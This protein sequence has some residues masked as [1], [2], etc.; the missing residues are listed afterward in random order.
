MKI[1]AV[2]FCSNGPVR[3]GSTS[4][5]SMRNSWD[6]PGKSSIVGLLGSAMG[7]NRGDVDSLIEIQNSIKLNMRVH[8]L[9]A[10]IKD[11]QTADTGKKSGKALATRAM[12]SGC[13]I[14]LALQGSDDT[15]EKIASALQKPARTLYIGQYGMLPDVPFIW[16]DCSW[17]EVSSP[18]ELL[19]IHKS[20]LPGSIYM[21]RINSKKPVIEIVRFEDDPNIPS[22][23]CM[24]QDIITGKLGRTSGMRYGPRYEYVIRFRGSRNLEEENESK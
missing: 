14:T 2:S 21:D 9:G 4:I 13:A 6:A 22:F 19:T 15:L 18:L 20:K 8:R 5:G 24:K 10:R 1:L 11:F 17:F 12:Y 7:V 16:P 23:R 3:F